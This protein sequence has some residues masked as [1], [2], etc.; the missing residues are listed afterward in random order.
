MTY[1]IKD[2]KTDEVVDEVESESLESLLEDY[3]YSKEYFN[4]EEV[5]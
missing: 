4:I 2:Q 3:D 5:A 1:I